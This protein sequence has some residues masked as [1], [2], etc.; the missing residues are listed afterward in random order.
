M[1]R[2]T[3][4]DLLRGISASLRQSVLPSLGQ[5]AAQRQLKAA[6]HTLGRLERSWDLLPAYLEADNADMRECLETILGALKASGTT[7]PTALTSLE[8][9]VAKVQDGQVASIA[10]FNDRA[11]AM[12][13]ALN[14]SLQALV[15]EVDGWLR[16]P[17][18]SANQVVATN[19]PLLDALYSRMVDRELQAWATDP[20]ET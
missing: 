13:G 3:T 18:Q 12:Q 7:P 8:Q 17:P 20:Q 9:T 4:S 5:G 10:G 6:L 14:L 19:I 16:A 2:P 11:L 1:L 15:V